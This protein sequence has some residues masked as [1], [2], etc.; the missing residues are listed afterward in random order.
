MYDLDSSDSRRQVPEPDL[1]PIMD[2][3][4]AVI[5]FM[6]LSITFIGMTKI[7]IPPSFV[8]A[9][10]SSTATPLSPIVKANLVGEQVRVRLEWIGT[11][12][13][14]FEEMA[15]R[16]G[17]AGKNDSLIDAARILSEKF[18]E[19]F[20]DE[21][22]IQIALAPELNYQ[23]LISIMDGLRTNHNDLVLT[24]YHQAE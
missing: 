9:A 16:T 17:A 3:L 20:P 14:H 5:F 12:P 4:T 10:G 7:S 8:S 23:E 6:L 24:S 11:K 2:A 1:V 18:K 21:K 15:E 13:G 22:S 19:R